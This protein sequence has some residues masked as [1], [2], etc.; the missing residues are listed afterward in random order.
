MGLLNGA[1][2]F[3][4]YRV[5]GTRPEEFTDHI[6]KGLKKYAFSDYRDEHREKNLGWTSLENILDTDFTY[7][8]YKCGDYLLFSLRT[9]RR[10]VPPTLLKLKILEAEKKYIAETGKI[11]LYRQEREEL[12]ERSRFSLMEKVL[13]VPAFHDIC[14]SLSRNLVFFGSH[15]EKVTD[16]F[17]NIFKESF[18]LSLTPFLPWEQ[19]QKFSQDNQDTEPA[20]NDTAHDAYHT[21]NPA[22]ASPIFLGREFLTWLWFKSEERNGIITVPEMG[23]NEIVFLQRLVLASGE[24]EYSE[25]VVC[26]GIH[27]DMQEGKEALRRGKKIKEARLKL[28]KD[29]MKWEFTF[30]ADMFQFQSLKLPAVMEIENDADREGLIIER[31]YLIE[32]VIDAMDNLFTRFL[33]LRSSILW[34]KEELPRMKKW[35]D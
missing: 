13:P 18:Q 11:K 32:K 26:Q 7:A 3:S 33:Q 4:R 16:D 14:W 17:L 34:E 31:I 5:L 29:S 12:K 19:G 20:I 2:T 10:A 6:D 28:V 25:T 30:Q 22:P 23:E 1:W 35:L 27:A 9:D 21:D 8:N 24:N 15:S